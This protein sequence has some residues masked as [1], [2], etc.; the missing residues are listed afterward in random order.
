MKK[1]DIYQF[2]DGEL[3]PFEDLVAEE[4]ILHLEI[5]S[6]TSFDVMITPNDIKEFVYGNL[7]SEGFIRDKSEISKYQETI[8]KN[9]ITVK[10]KIQDFRD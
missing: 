1:L 7:Y 10:V 5:N 3:L 2:R 4:A 9:L 8:K 6:D